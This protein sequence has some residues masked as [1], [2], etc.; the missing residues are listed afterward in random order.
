MANAR[1]DFESDVAGFQVTSWT[2]QDLEKERVT[3]GN[4]DGDPKPS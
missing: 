2:N 1:I 4:Q 3:Q